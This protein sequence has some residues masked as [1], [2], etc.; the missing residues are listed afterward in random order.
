MS[1]P[2]TSS[3]TARERGHLGFNIGGALLNA[4]GTIAGINTGVS[5]NRSQ[6]FGLPLVGV[7]FRVF[8]IPAAPKFSVSGGAKGMSAGAY[9]YFAEGRIRAGYDVG[10]VTF[11]G[12]WGILDADIHQTRSVAPA[13]PAPRITGPMV[14]VQ[15][16]F[17]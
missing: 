12:G 10:P 2:A 7:E 9:G 1:T 17:R 3:T 11:L 14:G 5:A 6:L 13:G 8:P 4:E 16:R 15:I